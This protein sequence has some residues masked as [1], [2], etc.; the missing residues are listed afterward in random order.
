M[1]KNPSNFKGDNLPVE[2]VSEN[3]VQDF[4]NKLNTQT[5]KSYRLPTEAEWEYAARAGTTTAFYTGDCINT[6]QANY[7]GSSQD[8]NNCGAKTGV[9]K[10]TTVAVGSYPANPWGLY[11]MAGNVYEWTCSAYF[12]NYDGSEKQC[13]SK[14]DVSTS[15]VLR[16]GSW[17]N[18]ARHARS[19]YRNYYTP[20]NRS[21]IIG[22][23]FALGQTA[24]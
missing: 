7:D 21:S 3:D 17:Y 18:F 10:Q 24:S 6:Q 14:N 9:Y 23:R 15:R 16:G 4:I 20:D 1:G 2:Q 13:V 19:A 11:D 8:Y 5:G 12:G 22:F